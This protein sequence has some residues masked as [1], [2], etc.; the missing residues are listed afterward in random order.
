MLMIGGEAVNIVI[1]DEDNAAGIRLYNIVTQ[2]A[3]DDS[4]RRFCISE[5]LYEYARHNYINVAFIS[6]DD[7]KGKGVFIASNLKKMYPRINLVFL[8]E[9]M[10]YDKVATQLRVSG[11][12]TSCPTEEMVK[13]ELMC[14]RYK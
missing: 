5:Q 3:P 1:Y 14:L 9:E 8:S 11:Y 12:I 4:V 10:I 6:V 2:S 13:D 7:K